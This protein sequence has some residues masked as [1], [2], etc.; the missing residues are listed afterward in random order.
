VK[1][2]LNLGM[3]NFGST[4]KIKW[5]PP[6]TNS[7]MFNVDGAHS[8]INDFSACGGLFKDAQGGLIQGFYGN[9]GCNNSQCAEM[10]NLFDISC[11]LYFS[12][13]PYLLCYF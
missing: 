4:I 7:L 9:L 1:V 13:S 12:S 6:P 5:E 11:C 10:F 3:D 8:K 2:L